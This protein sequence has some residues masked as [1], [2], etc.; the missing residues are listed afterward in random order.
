MMLI[1]MSYNP[2][3]DQQQPLLS[4][5]SIPADSSIIW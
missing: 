3:T 5:F 2:L 1:L 4:F